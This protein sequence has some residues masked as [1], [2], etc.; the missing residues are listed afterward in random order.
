MISP[1]YCDTISSL[2][3]TNPEDSQ[4]K[5]QSFTTAMPLRIIVVG[6][7]I[8]GLS[9]AVSLRQAGHTVQVSIDRILA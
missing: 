4:N 1:C 3:I 6:A 7:G 8:A 2:N 5:E 9:A